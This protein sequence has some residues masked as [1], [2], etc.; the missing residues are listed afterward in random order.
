MKPLQ[1][2]LIKLLTRYALKRGS[3]PK[4][5]Q[6][7]HLTPKRWVECK[8]EFY[9]NGRHKLKRSKLKLFVECL[10]G[11]LIGHE[12]SKTERGYGGGRM[13][14]CSCRWCDKTIQVPIEET[15]DRYLVNI[16]NY[17]KKSS[18]DRGI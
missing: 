15:N 2:P 8:N 13:I 4:Y 7:W 18:S 16:F 6:T 12:I 17:L 11:A 3:N 10:C 9:P 1:R 5:P 14:D